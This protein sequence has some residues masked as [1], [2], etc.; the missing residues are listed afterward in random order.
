MD[1]LPWHGQ[2][3]HFGAVSLSLGI[4]SVDLW[5]RPMEAKKLGQLLW[6]SEGMW[7]LSVSSLHSER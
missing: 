5:C 6:A 4:V 2:N 7:A 1:A 3:A